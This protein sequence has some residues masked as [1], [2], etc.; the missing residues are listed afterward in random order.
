MVK[1]YSL[2]QHL[3]DYFQCS[4][5]FLE[6]CEVF[7]SLPYAAI[8]DDR[9]LCLHGGL[10]PHL[11]SLEMI[12]T[13]PRPLDVGDSGLAFDLLWSDPSHMYEGWTINDRG[14]G[15]SFG[16]DIVH[17]FCKAHDLGLI[18]RGHEVPYDGYHYF[19]DKKLV[20]INSSA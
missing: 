2:A 7:C 12:N 5:P 3:S 1:M 16:A 20:T 15:Y 11:Q 13:I 19:A 4:T 14:L 10:S 18:C 6:V 9:G 8:V 17:L